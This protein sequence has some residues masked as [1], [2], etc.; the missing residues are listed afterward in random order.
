MAIDKAVDSAALD[1][2]LVGI[3][4]AIRGKTDGTDPLTLDTMAAAIEGLNVGSGS[5]GDAAAEDALVTGEY[6]HYENDRVETIGNYV[7]TQKT[8][9]ESVGFSSVRSFTGSNQFNGCTALR[10]IDFPRLV[11]AT[12]GNAFRGCSSLTEVVFPAY[13]AASPSFQGCTALTLVDLSNGD[14]PA[15]EE[16]LELG[17]SAN[18]FNGCTSLNTIILRKTSKLA[19]L[20]NAS[21]FTGTPFA[22]GG[23][24]GTVYVPASL[25]QE[26]QQATNWS[27]L[28]AAGTCNFVEIEGSVY[29]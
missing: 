8:K 26:Y 14:A 29:E 13:N 17:V 2:A 27:A 23:A 20:T 11:S 12:G 9:L 10:Q 18:C 22:V 28:Y 7:F 6:T 1:A 15:R 19:S 25:I 16:N 5:G 4:D 21:A 3:A 24:G